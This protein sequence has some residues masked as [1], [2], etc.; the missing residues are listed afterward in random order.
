M[1]TFKTISIKTGLLLLL[2][3][4]VFFPLYPGLFE[5]WLNDSNNSH[6][7]LVPFIAA[8]FIWQKRDEVKDLSPQMDLRGAL[9]FIASLVVYI[10]SFAGAI[11][12]AARSM[13][14]FSLIGLVLYNYGPVIFKKLAFPLFFFYS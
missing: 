10:L 4:A 9:L 13:I 8:F 3:A 14:V 7:I 5:T 2:W 1:G 6:G 12:V 11:A